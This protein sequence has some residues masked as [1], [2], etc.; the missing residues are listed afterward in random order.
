MAMKPG[1]TRALLFDKD[2]TLFDFEATWTPVLT[3]L[4]LEAAHGDR[5][6]A[7]ALL[8]AGGLDPASGR[9]RAGSIIGAGTTETIVDLW[10]PGAGPTE[11][12]AAVARI[13]RAFHAHGRDSSVPFDD[14]AGTLAEL[15]AAG[16]A[17]GV[18]TNDGTAA[19][20]AALAAS[21]LGA[22]LPH[23]FG[24]DAVAR[25]KPAPDMVFAFCAA[26]GVEP[27]EVAV[28]GDNPHDMEMARGAGV[29]V[30][31]G[32]ASG[33][34]SAAELA[35]LADAVIGRLGDLPGWLH[36]NRK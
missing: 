24:Y 27:G 25:A 36:Q 31:I 19:A 26:C 10:Y 33:N 7:T 35:P 11:R 6:A 23:V 9:Y 14:V 17:M 15:S 13:D 32:V 3:R 29:G 34:S 12:A 5:E 16:Y 8:V 28:V 30:A 20:V 18:A 21:G 1:T 2:G 22:F 4:A